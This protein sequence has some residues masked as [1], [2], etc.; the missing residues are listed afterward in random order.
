MYLPR[1][2]V[3]LGHQTPPLG[4]SCM[5]GARK[6]DQP[7]WIIIG[8]SP[9]RP[10]ERPTLGRPGSVDLQKMPAYNL[11]TSNLAAVSIFIKTNS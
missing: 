7:F 3:Q 9:S 5:K 1:Q 4:H 8:D 11:A 10:A 6:L 2:T